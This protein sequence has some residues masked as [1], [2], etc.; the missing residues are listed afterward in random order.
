MSKVCVYCK[1]DC[2]NKPRLKDAD[3]HYACKACAQKHA[4]AASR[5]GSQ[6]HAAPNPKRE[7]AMS[8]RHHRAQPPSSE[9]AALDGG[10]IDLSA[11]LAASEHVEVQLQAM[12]LCPTC[13]TSNLPAAEVC[14]ECGHNFISGR[15]GPTPEERAARASA[16]LVGIPARATCEKCNYSLQGL[17]TPICPECGHINP[18]DAAK[19][20]HKDRSRESA[21]RYW[22][23]PVIMIAASLP[24]AAGFHTYMVAHAGGSIIKGLFVFA[25]MQAI[26]V[27]CSFVV[28]FALCLTFFG[29]SQS[30]RLAALSLLAVATTTS[31]ISVVL[32]A[33]IP[34]PLIPGLITTFCYC[35]IAADLLDMELKEAFFFGIL[36]SVATGVGGALFVVAVLAALG[37]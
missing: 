19:V 22:M 28:Y 14:R 30:L 23:K 11:V 37:M 1:Q 13:E 35:G 21:K 12:R 26:Y 34:L 5:S 32:S 29:F 2:S 24:I 36:S 10:E 20:D 27:A 8:A 25:L 9:A 7:T 4:G 16:K 33:L 18:T 3:G 15:A 17:R 6:P 31:A